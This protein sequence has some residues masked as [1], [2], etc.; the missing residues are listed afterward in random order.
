M[1]NCSISQRGFSLIELLIVCVII[2]IIAAIAIP[3]VLAAKQATYSASA[4]SSLRVINQCENSYR[5]T[6]GSFGTAVDLANYGL[7]NDPDI[8][9][10][11][12]SHYQFTINPDSTDPS[13]DYT[14]EA[15]PMDTPVTFWF[16]YFVDATGVIRKNQGAR[17]DAT[18]TPID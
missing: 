1:A 14:A 9:T 2:G 10:G 8:P 5:A 16:H 7:L 15:V 11:Q 3:Y 12:K 4:I 17:A 6:T 18:S 13:Q